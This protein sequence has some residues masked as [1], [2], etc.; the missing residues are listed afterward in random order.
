M[1]QPKERGVIP[2]KFSLLITPKCGSSA[3]KFSL[4]TVAGNPAAVHFFILARLTKSDER[5][6]ENMLLFLFPPRLSQ[7]LPVSVRRVGSE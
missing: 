3:L 7:I 5:G 2:E 1:P 4:R 6:L